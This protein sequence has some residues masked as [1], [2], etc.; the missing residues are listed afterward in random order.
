MDVLLSYG[1]R[2]TL[3]EDAFQG[4]LYDYKEN[5]FTFGVSFSATDKWYK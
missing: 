2:K 5:F 4:C 3:L 1:Q